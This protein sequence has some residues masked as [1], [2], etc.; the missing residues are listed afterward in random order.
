MGT[1]LQWISDFSIMLKFIYSEKA[2]KFAK[3][4]ILLL[5]DTTFLQNFV[6][7]SEYMNFNMDLLWLFKYWF[8]CLQCTILKVQLTP[9]VFKTVLNGKWHLAFENISLKNLLFAK[10]FQNSQTP[11]Q[12]IRVDFELIKYSVNS[13]HILLSQI[14][15][16]MSLGIYL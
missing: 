11:K 1:I 7:F 16:Q 15:R 5:T 14:G 4:S 9:F 6:A 8:K 13:R 10:M 3:I 12:A 2:T